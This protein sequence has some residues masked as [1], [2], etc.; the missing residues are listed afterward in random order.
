MNLDAA[1]VDSLVLGS[2]PDPFDR[3]KG[4]Q[5][6]PR[7]PYA[8][9]RCRREEPPLIES[10]TPGHLYRCWYPVRDVQAEVG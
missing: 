2:T 5:F 6:A 3:P 9:D 1:I 7:C 10:E 8:Q 4:C